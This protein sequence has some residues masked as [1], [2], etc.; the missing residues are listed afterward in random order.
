MSG[1]EYADGIRDRMKISQVTYGKHDHYGCLTYYVYCL[2]DNGSSGQGFGNTILQ[3]DAEST[4]DL[5]ISLTGLFGPPSQDPDSLQSLVG[6]EIF[7]L[8]CNPYGD[9]EGIESVKTGRRFLLI[10]WKRKHWPDKYQASFSDQLFIDYKRRVDQL[11]N[12]I[13][14]AGNDFHRHRSS[15]VDW[16]IEP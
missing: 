2:S 10:Q 11:Q 12:D 6:E 9:I 15:L 14:R 7:A 16:E 8:R 3:E 13:V 4:R 5:I 1:K